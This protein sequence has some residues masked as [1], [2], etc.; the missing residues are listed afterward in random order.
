MEGK[1][2]APPEVQ[3]APDV[4]AENQILD[5]VADVLQQPLQERRTRTSRI[6][7]G[8]GQPLLAVPLFAGLSAAELLAVVQGLTLRTFESGDIS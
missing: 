7:I 5:L 3:V 1:R 6:G 4:R 2:S 8:A